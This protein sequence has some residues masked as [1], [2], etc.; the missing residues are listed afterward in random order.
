MILFRT[1]KAIDD[2]GPSADV[3]ARKRRLVKERTE[4]GAE[5]EFRAR[6]SGVCYSLIMIVN[7]RSDFETNFRIKIDLLAPLTLQSSTL[8]SLKASAKV[9][10][11]SSS[12]VKTL[13]APLPQRFQERLDRHAAY[14]QTKEEVDKWSEA[15]KHIRDASFTDTY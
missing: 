13:S 15:M 9:L 11:S 2:V 5:N 7:L 10:T 1:W 4:T 6:S 14:E 12:K 8:Q 3:P